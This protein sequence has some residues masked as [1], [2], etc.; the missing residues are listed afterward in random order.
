LGGAEVL[1]RYLLQDDAAQAEK[2]RNVINDNPVVLINNVVLVETLWTL[3]G[4]KYRLTHDEVVTT[5]QALFAEP[6]IVFGQAQTVWRALGDYVAANEDGKGKVDFPDALIL[7]IGRE[8]A[9]NSDSQ[10]GGFFTF[11]KAAL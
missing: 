1:L 4:K 9:R 7:N 3:C 2:A 6:N 5:V 11:H 10:F 8:V